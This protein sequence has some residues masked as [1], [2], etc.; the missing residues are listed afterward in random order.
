MAAPV[1][2]IGDAT[3]QTTVE[4]KTYPSL[5]IM[6]HTGAVYHVAVRAQDEQLA[7]GTETL[8][9]EQSAINT[10][11]TVTLDAG[12]YRAE[13]RGGSGGLPA[14][15]SAGMGKVAQ[16][17]VINT[18]IIK[19]DVSSTIYTFRGGDGNNS[20]AINKHQFPGGGASGVDSV[21]V[22]P[23]RTIRAIG[24]APV[25]CT[26]QA[27]DAFPSGG[28][29]SPGHCIG[30][31]ANSNGGGGVWGTPVAGGCGGGGG[32]APNGTGG[33]AAKNTTAGA[34]A[35]STGG[36]NGGDATN[37]N[38]DSK[39]SNIGH[40]GA[41]GANVTWQC[42]GQ[43]ITSYGGGGGGGMCA[44]VMTKNCNQNGSW[45]YSDCADGGDGGSG[46]TGTST[47][48]Y[49]KIYRIG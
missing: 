11:E 48:S 23:T 6:D 16:L 32:G 28:W 4:Q 10:C 3:I 39:T 9:Y 37:P 31:A 49:V 18:T 36:G 47:D 17:G 8:V 1:I 21:I 34:D 5:H 38:G 35:T 41:G 42:G 30:G 14:R 2:H 29:S 46:S 15:C 20:G 7:T 25:Q 22:L 40:G 33:V 13:L 43:T 27:L 19:L 44:W 12:L 26:A 45:C 24:G